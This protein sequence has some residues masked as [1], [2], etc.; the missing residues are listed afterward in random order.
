[1][2]KIINSKCYSTHETV[3]TTIGRKMLKLSTKILTSSPEPK[4]KK[5]RQQ[6]EMLF[7]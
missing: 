4:S 5:V 7:N 1:M 6:L 2:S 3:Y